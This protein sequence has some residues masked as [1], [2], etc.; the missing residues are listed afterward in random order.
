MSKGSKW[1]KTDYK[2]F[3]SNFD[4]INWRKKDLTFQVLLNEGNCILGY[5]HSKSEVDAKNK[6]SRMFSIAEKFLTVSLID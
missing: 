3:H 2:S 5:V 1:R 4:D 6:A